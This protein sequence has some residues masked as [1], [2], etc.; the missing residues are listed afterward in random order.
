MII[1][2]VVLLLYIGRP[3]SGCPD[4]KSP[5]VWV[6]ISA[7]ACWKLQRAWARKKA[8]PKDSTPD[9]CQM[10]QL[11]LRRRLKAPAPPKKSRPLLSECGHFCLVTCF[12][13]REFPK[14]R[15]PNVDPN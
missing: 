2:T 12:L 8:K 3:F 14:I 9:L 5:V 11:K 10:A 1:G 13:V 4:H 6:Y 15:A 7:P